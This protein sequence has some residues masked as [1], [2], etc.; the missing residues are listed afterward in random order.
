LRRKL[1]IFS[2]F[3]AFGVGFT[4]HT[5]ELLG[6][7]AEQKL[8]IIN[9]DDFGMCHAENLATME[10]LKD[11][12]ITSA[13]IMIPCPWVVEAAQFCVE[14]PGLDVGVHLT[15]TAEWK[16][17]K[18]GSVASHDK[19]PSLLNEF[20]FFPPD[21][22]SV[23]ENATLEQ[24]ELEMRAQL[25][26]AFQLGIKPTHFDNHMGSLYGLATGKN[27][28][29]QIFKLAAEYKL[30]FRLPRNMG[31]KYQ[32]SLP[33]ESIAMLEQ[34]TGQLV[35]QGFVLPD[36]LESISYGK[37]YEESFEA[38]VNLFKSL[39]PGVT[40]LYIHAALPTDE[41]K[42]ISNAWRNRDHDYRICKSDEIKQ[43]IKDMNI[44]LITWKELQELQNKQLKK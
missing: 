16:R 6:Y 37:T 22:R 12:H 32:K 26:K 13:T 33:K 11:G 44:K 19:V 34:M 8:L 25:D 3:I 23:E 43:V 36:Y 5:G 20:G 4:Q 27:Y 24:V 35:S 42:A 39:K 30:P 1:V 40:E 10:L 17:Y 15:F 9:A 7:D 18:W 21:I 41:M 29:A 31:E 38:F 2:I 14:N 28:F